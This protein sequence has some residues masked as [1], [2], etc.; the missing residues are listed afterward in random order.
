VEKAIVWSPGYDLKL[1]LTLRKE[2]KKMAKKVRDLVCGIEF[3]EDSASSIV[4]YYDKIY[5]FCCWRC[6]EK[7]GRE[8]E[9]YVNN[10]E[11]EIVG[12]AY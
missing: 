6:N 2:I 10:Q 8:P 4:E 11:R 9:K 12:S 1:P 5:Y 7:F 3:D